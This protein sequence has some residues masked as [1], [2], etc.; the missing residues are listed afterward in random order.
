MSCSSHPGRRDRLLFLLLALTLVRG[1][2]YIAVIPPWQ[3]PDE[4]FHFLS[5]QSALLQ[6]APDAS[7]KWERLKAETAASL[8]EFRFWE[9]AGLVVRKPEGCCPEGT[10]ACPTYGF[11]EPT[12]IRPRTFTHALLS[13]PLRLV[14]DQPVIWQL[15]WARLLSVLVN[16][17]VVA[18]AFAVGRLLFPDDVFGRL[19]LPTIIV[20]LPQHTAVMAAVND[21]NPAELWSCLAIYFWVRGIVKGFKWHGLLLVAVFTA[22]AAASKPTTYFLVPPLLALLIGYGWQRLQGWWRLAPLGGA[23]CLIAGLALASERFR[24]PLALLGSL[25]DA[26]GEGFTQ[27]SLA[28]LPTALVETLRSFWAFLGWNALPVS[29]AWIT[30]MLMLS[31][32][33]VAG[34][35]RLGWRCWR[36]Q[37]GRGPGL[38]LCHTALF[39]CACIAISLAI[40]LIVFAYSAGQYGLYQGRYLFPA[41]IPIVGLLVIGWRACLPTG[42]RREGLIAV[43]AL[44]LVFDTAVLLAY[45]LPFFYPLWR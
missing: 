41:I 23:A 36:G 25:L 31:A 7:G 6:G 20:F 16:L 39:F 38:A 34:L 29:D 10:G 19:L 40:M 17:A 45:A 18:I 28:H 35:L 14:I 5:A 22:L 30:L 15:Y 4:P 44:F 42:W 8:C 9:L 24:H 26:D 32:L 21:G 11:G 3:S 37:A 27:W 2:I 43:A 13:L 33:C 1:L 12:Q